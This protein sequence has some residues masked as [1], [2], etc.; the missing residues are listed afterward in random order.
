MTDAENPGQEVVVAAGEL[1]DPPL[2]RFRVWL[3]GESEGA[4]WMTPF[5]D[6][7]SFGTRRPPGAKAIQ[8]LP[9][10]PAGRVTVARG[11]DPDLELRLLFAG[12]DPVSRQARHELSRRRKVAELAAGL[13]MPQGRVVAALWDGGR[14]RY[15]ALSRPFEVKAGEVLSAPLE[16]PSARR[17][18]LVVYVDRPPGA[19]EL[20]IPGFEITV[21]QPDGPHAADVAVETPWGLYAFWYDLAPGAWT[22]EGANDRLYLEPA[23]LRLEGGEITRFQDTLAPLLDLSGT[24]GSPK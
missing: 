20:S 8:L 24:S 10:V 5:T 4:W 1:F 14:G 15:V 6:L 9:V 22:V 3:Q 18:H 12:G 11:A 21:T 13:L 16:T 7:V 2:G 17:S 23:R 19:P